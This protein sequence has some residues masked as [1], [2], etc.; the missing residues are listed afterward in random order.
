[1]ALQELNR[2]T[3][4]DFTNTVPDFIVNSRALDVTEANPDEFFWY[5]DKAPQ[6]YGYYLSIP[7]IFSATNALATWQ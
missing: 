3:T 2:A 6:N 7:E 1:M 5:F 4:T